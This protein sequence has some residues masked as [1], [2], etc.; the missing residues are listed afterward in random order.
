MWLHFWLAPQRMLIFSRSNHLLDN[1][2]NLPRSRLEQF[3]AGFPSPGSLLFQIELHYREAFA[4]INICPK[5]NSPTIGEGRTVSRQDRNG[6][7]SHG[8]ILKK[9]CGY[10]RQRRT[11]AMRSA[12]RA[13]WKTSCG[14]V[15]RQSNSKSPIT[16]KLHKCYMPTVAHRILGHLMR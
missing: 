1:E 4:M 9:E 5:K 16:E 6:K 12:T 8:R 15:G 10:S 14:C 2:A 13:D 3:N 7:A 11:Y